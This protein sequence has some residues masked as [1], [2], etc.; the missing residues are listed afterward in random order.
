[1][2]ARNCYLYGSQVA[3]DGA[4]YDSRVR[5]VAKFI[6]RDTTFF[7]ADTT[8]L[9]VVFRFCLYVVFYSF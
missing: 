5:D 3:Y 2:F 9:M 7:A 4:I 1:M 8:L 6:D